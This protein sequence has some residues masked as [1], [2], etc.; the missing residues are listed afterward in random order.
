M[1][2]G[3]QIFNKMNRLFLIFSLFTIFPVLCLYGE[4]SNSIPIDV[5]ISNVLNAENKMKLYMYPLSKEHPT[6]RISK[7]PRMYWRLETQLWMLIPK[8]MWTDDP[9]KADFYVFIH[10]LYGNWDRGNNQ[11]TYI[12][13]VLYPRLFEIYHKYPYFNRTNGR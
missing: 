1:E 10:T 5:L 9:E 8:D 4:V 6:R 12:N 7:L 11:F 3:S 2:N 13:K